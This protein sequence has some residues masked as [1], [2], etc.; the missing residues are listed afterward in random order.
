MR[1][2]LVTH[3][4]P[5]FGL[6]GVERVA[7]QTALSLTGAGHEVIVLSRRESAAPPIPKVERTQRRGIEVVM[8]SG[9]GPLH[10]RFPKLSA[11]LDR[12]FERTLIECEPDVVLI[13]HLMNHSPGYVAVAHRWGVPVVLELHDYYMAC[14]QARLQRTSG[15]LCGGPEGGRACAV[16]CFPEQERSLERW[17]LRTRLFRD[18]LE[19]ADALLTPSQF[20]ADYFHKLYGRA[21]PPLHVIG[22]GIDTANAPLRVNDDERPFSVGYIGAVTQHKGVHILVDALRQAQLP[23][24]RL[25]LFGVVTQPYFGELLETAQKID[26]LQFQA[27]GGFE[28]AELPILLGGVDV[29]VVPSI[30]WE[31]YSIVIREAFACGIPVIA[32]RLGALP[33]AVRDGKNGFLFSPGDSLELATML[34]ALDSDR[35]QLAALR[36]GIRASD[37]MSVEERMRQLREVLRTVVE[38]A[39]LKTPMPEAEELA[40]LRDALVAHAPTS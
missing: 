17:A 33:E 21:L 2:L 9:G 4:Y 11:V 30:W 7:E 12:L 32:S 8:L 25:T 15:E 34:R 6:T 16:H 28:V 29:V 36:N 5:P 14:E 20:V 10:G 40:I 19:Q 22:N 18:A 31:T 39:P 37:W 3:L 26:N 27:Y 1:V 13:S 23:N 24:A 35:N 38:Q